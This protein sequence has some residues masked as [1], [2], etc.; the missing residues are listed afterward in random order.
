MS[1][2]ARLRAFTLVELLVVIGI[3][4]L[5]ISI[6]LPSLHKARAAAIRTQCLSNLLRRSALTW[7]CTPTPTKAL[8]IGWVPNGTM[9][10]GSCW[11]GLQR[12]ST[13]GRG[14]IAIGYLFETGIVPM[15][16]GQR[17]VFHCPTQPEDWAYNSV[18]E[19]DQ[20]TFNNNGGYISKDSGFFA[21][22]EDINSWPILKP[23]LSGSYE[24]HIGYDMRRTSMATIR[25]NGA[26]T[27][28]PR[29]S[30]TP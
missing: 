23:S 17:R 9:Q 10:W 5:L 14:P 21:D 15:W 25:V 12:S 28:S 11:V 22:N 3:I 20:T 8:L 7:R 19:F 2:F 4:A 13:L 26:G 30:L 16:G 18:V 1:R 6:L 29:I 24:S 27:S